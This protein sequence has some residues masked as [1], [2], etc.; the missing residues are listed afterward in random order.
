MT[1]ADGTTGPGAPDPALAAHWDAAYAQGEATRSWFEARPTMSLRMLRAA[2]LAP[3][4]SVLDVG[5]GASRLVDALLEDGVR[6]PTVLDISEAALQ[7]A[8]QRIGTQA[9]RVRWVRA[10]IRS[11]SPPTRF[12]AW[13]DRAVLHF[14]LDPADQA[15]YLRTLAAATAPGSIAVF[16]CFAPDGPTHCSGLPVARRSAAD[17]AGLLGSDWTLVADDVE[18]HPTPAG[19]V[20]PFTWAAFV[21]RP[22]A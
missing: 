2:G 16:G 11:W 15:R 19:G 18:Q 12:G 3:A 14:L 5:G 22:T 6:Q 7:A 17:L 8:K 9:H 10:D 20:Q 1:G 13:H 21:Q 4:A